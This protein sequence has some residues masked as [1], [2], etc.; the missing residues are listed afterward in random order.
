MT[1]PARREI[2]DAFRGALLTLEAGRKAF[3]CHALEMRR[4]PGAE[5]AKS[6]ILQRLYPFDTYGEWLKK[7]SPEDYEK[8]YR[9]PASRIAPRLFWLSAL[10]K[11]FSE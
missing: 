3:I 2:A 4:T 8:R 5:A 11:E 7:N 10:I 1:S 9:Y 6:I